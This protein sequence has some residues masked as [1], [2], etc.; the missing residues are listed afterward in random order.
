MKIEFEQRA[1][2]DGNVLWK[3]T[4]ATGFDPPLCAVATKPWVA[5]AAVV[6]AAVRV[7]TDSGEPV[8]A[9]DIEIAW[10]SLPWPILRE[11]YGILESVSH[12]L[13][14]SREMRMAI[15]RACYAREMDETGARRWWALTDE[16]RARFAANGAL[17]CARRALGEGDARWLDKAAEWAKIA[18]AH[19]SGLDYAKAGV[20]LAVVRRIG[21]SDESIVVLREVIDR[22]ESANIQNEISFAVAN[23]RA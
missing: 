14:A 18:S 2:G 6:E 10:Q 12:I 22:L 15:D 17:L 3:A 20:G 5:S 21:W 19:S 7:G 23:Q 1:S 13:G 9:N 8:D 11:A 4:M 16:E